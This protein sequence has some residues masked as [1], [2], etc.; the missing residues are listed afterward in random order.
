MSVCDCPMQ[1]EASCAI[2]TAADAR[3]EA[4]RAE[5]RVRVNASTERAHNALMNVWRSLRDDASPTALASACALTW[6]AYDAGIVD[7]E[8]RELWARRFQTCPGHDDEG[9]RTWCAYCGEHPLR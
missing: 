1:S 4:D 3:E 2:C 5:L 8:Q 7:S 9:G 6:F